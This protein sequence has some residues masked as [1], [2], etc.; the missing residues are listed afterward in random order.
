MFEFGFDLKFE[1]PT[2]VGQHGVLLTFYK[3]V[4]LQL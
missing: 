3:Q 1:T 4:E 2:Q